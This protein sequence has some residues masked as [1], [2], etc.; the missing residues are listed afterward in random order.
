MTNTWGVHNDTFTTELIDGGFISVGWDRLGDLREIGLTRDS[1]KHALSDAYPEDKPQAI[2]GR[3]GVLLRFAAEMTVGDLIVAPYR[4]NG[5]INLG[6]VTGP[7][8]FDG[9]A[10]THRHRRRVRWEK[11]GISRTVFTQSALHEIGSLLAVFGIRRNDGE[12]QAAVSVK[13]ET[14][15]ERAVSEVARPAVSDVGAASSGADAV[16]DADAEGRASQVERQT[17]DFVLK[18][19]KNELTHREF[20]EFT[21]SLLQ[22]MGYEARATDYSHD[23]GV[24]VVAHRDPLGVEP[25]VLKIQCKHMTG[26]IGAPEVQQLIGTQGTGELCVFVTLGGYSRDAL[27]IERQRQGLRLLHGEDLIDLVLRHYDRLDQRW[28]SRIPL[29][30][31]LVVDDEPDI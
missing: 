12:F 1:L 13:D 23:G 2:A 26:T 14:Q 10:P 6:V 24:D 28:R 31:V 5:T 4:P 11:L 3:A 7:Y 9:N 15:V 22:A 18:T 27:S 17:R 29:R 21:A 25:P 20:E 19:L 8:Y 30:P 16:E